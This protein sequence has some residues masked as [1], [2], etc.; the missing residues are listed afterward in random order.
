MTALTWATDGVAAVGFLPA[1]STV[2]AAPL[3][4]E[5][6]L[7]VPWSPAQLPV[8][9]HA[10]VVIRDVNSPGKAAR[11][12]ARAGERD[13]EA[14]PT[15]SF[16]ICCRLT[17]SLLTSAS[18]LRRL[19]GSTITH[20]REET[21]DTLSCTGKDKRVHTR[22]QNAWR[23]SGRPCEMTMKITLSQLPVRC[24]SSSETVTFL[25]LLDDCVHSLMT[26]LSVLMLPLSVIFILA[27]RTKPLSSCSST[28]QRD[29]W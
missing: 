17:R 24:E 27:P 16:S 25:F 7:L 18:S 10:L 20:K 11:L 26:D 9:L 22:P 1:G 23:T 4:K 5:V 2:D 14:L 28:C 8:F 13:P 29:L 12:K 21:R 19:E 3:V 15:A 6:D